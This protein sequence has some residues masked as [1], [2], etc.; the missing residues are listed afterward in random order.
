LEFGLQRNYVL[1]QHRSRVRRPTAAATLVE[2]ITRRFLD[3]IQSRCLVR[4]SAV[5]L[6]VASRFETI[7]NHAPHDDVRMALRPHFQYRGRCL[8]EEPWG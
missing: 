1:G 8:V 5:R 2:H 3:G 7:I 4:P 6:L